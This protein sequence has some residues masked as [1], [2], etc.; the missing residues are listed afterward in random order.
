M[1]EHRQKHGHLS[2]IVVLFLS[3][4]SSQTNPTVPGPTPGS[5]AATRQSTATDTFSTSATATATTA[6]G[7]TATTTITTTTTAA[8]PSFAQNVLPLL[9]A[10]CSGCHPNTLFSL[11]YNSAVSHAA[12]ANFANGHHGATFS[13]TEN[14]TIQAWINGGK[15][16]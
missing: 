11:D 16:Q 12:S 15:A 2:V 13:A 9:Q 8:I 5:A 4:C 10:K 1:N 14:Q 3:S 7:N 6:N